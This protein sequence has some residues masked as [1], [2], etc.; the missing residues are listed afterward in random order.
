M[1]G[2]ALS[3]QRDVLLVSIVSDDQW[4]CVKIPSVD[5]LLIGAD[6]GKNKLKRAPLTGRPFQFADRNRHYFVIAQATLDAAPVD[7]KL[8]L[9]WGAANTA[10]LVDTKISALIAT[11]F[12]TYLHEP[13]SQDER[14]TGFSVEELQRIH[15]KNAARNHYLKVL[16]GV[17]AQGISALATLEIGRNLGLSSRSRLAP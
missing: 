11:N 1:G 14:K 4:M 2:A 10:A 6:G 3:F 8:P 17:R 5:A 7:L 13:A 9:Q 16:S 12:I 15:M